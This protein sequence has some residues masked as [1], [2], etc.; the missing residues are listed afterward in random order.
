MALGPLAAFVAF[1]AIGA[2]VQTLTGFAFGLIMMGSIALVG[3]LPLPDAAA[4]VG[5]LT[6]VNA[7]QM[8]IHGGWREVAR[9]ELRLILVSSLPSLFVGYAVLEWMADTRADLL[10][11]GLGLVIMLS[12]LQLAI[13]PSGLAKPSPGASFVGFGVI[14]GLM[15][16]LFATGGPPLVYHLFRQPMPHERIRETLVTA[17]GAAQAVRIV[18]VVAGGNLPAL[19]PVALILAVPIVILSTYAARRWP[20]ALSQRTVRRSVFV[21]L[22]LSGLSLTLPAAM[23][24]AA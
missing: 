21:L 18:L 20:P 6:L 14:S 17:F 22:F 3:L 2:Y 12:S 15:S 23:H 1:A 19:S 7:T 16:G 9:R 24:I 8:L 4:M 11:I 5:M 10:K 13:R